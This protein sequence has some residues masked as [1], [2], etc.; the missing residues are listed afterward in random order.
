MKRA[1]TF[2]SYTLHGEE[3]QACPAKRKTNQMLCTGLSKLDI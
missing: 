2:A 3:K 1:R